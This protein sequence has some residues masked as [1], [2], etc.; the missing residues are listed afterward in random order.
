MRHLP[1]LRLGRDTVSRLLPKSS[2]RLL[3]E[4][5]EKYDVVW[6]YCHRGRTE[7]RAGNWL[8]QTI[9]SWADISNSAAGPWRAIH[10]RPALD[11]LR[12][13]HTVHLNAAIGAVDDLP[14]DHAPP[15]NTGE[16]VAEWAIL[17]MRRSRPGI[18]LRVH[19]DGGRPPPVRVA[20]TPDE[21]ASPY[22]HD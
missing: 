14:W 11:G 19:P 12:C 6:A 10:V 17:P 7:K 9:Q 2:V 3:V 4:E 22:D 16:F 8:R 21:G 1:S 13:V 5:T 18:T 20:A 15:V